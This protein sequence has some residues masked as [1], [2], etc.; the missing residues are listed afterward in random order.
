MSIVVFVLL[1]LAVCGFSHELLSR[2]GIGI[3]VDL[4]LGV[5][6]AVAAGSFFNRIVETSA[7][8]NVTCALVVALTGAVVLL[9]VY[10]F[11]V[12]ETRYRR[13]HSD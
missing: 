7:G 8:R 5:I 3:T 10:H 11:T 4:C 1:G 12:H 13:H 6:G 9:A 2:S